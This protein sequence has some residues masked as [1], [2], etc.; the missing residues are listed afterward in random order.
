MEKETK[1]TKGKQI[2]NELE[3]CLEAW[4]GETVYDKKYAKL[5]IDACLFH[6]YDQSIDKDEMYKFLE[7]ADKE[8]KRIIVKPDAEFQPGG[9]KADQCDGWT[10]HLEL[11]EKNEYTEEEKYWSTRGRTGTLPSHITPSRINSLLDDEI[12]VFGSN[13]MGMHMGGAARIAYDKFGAEWGN[14]EGLQGQ[15]YALPTME[16]EESV[17]AAIKRFT[18]FAYDHPDLTFFVTAVGCGIA[19]YTPKEIA[20][21]FESAANLENVY[22][23]LSFW[24]ILAD[25]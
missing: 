25:K 23:P 2:F 13:A 9:A 12:F 17:R 20:P 1:Y 11:I 3:R 10:Y 6:G 22:L 24:K 4:D 14:G 19:G 8:N 18:E 16:G 21:I 7:M 15:S 5:L